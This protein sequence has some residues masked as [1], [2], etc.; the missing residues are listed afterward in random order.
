MNTKYYVL[1]TIVEL[2]LVLH[3]YGFQDTL[4][5]KI[6]IDYWSKTNMHATQLFI[7]FNITRTTNLQM[8]RVR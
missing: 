7:G 1:I 6:I 4:L 2:I 3:N 8:V 5:I